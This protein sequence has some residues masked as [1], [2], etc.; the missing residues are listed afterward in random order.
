M[1]AARA[2]AGAAGDTG[3]TPAAPA[4]TIRDRLGALWTEALGHPDIAADADFFDLGG[5]SLTAV[6]LMARIREV[7]DV[8][9]S[10]AVMFEHPTLGG[11]AEA[12]RGEGVR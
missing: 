9:M 10:I 1:G 6:E 2:P 4:G 12:L 11:L 8:R 3:R 7:F 5:N